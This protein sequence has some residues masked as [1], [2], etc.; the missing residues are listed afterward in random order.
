MQF[1]DEFEGLFHLVTEWIKVPRTFENFTPL[2]LFRC[3]I[4]SAISSQ[5][6]KDMSDIFCCLTAVI[7]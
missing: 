3:Q 6:W 1:F 2:N 7:Q 5:F 4:F